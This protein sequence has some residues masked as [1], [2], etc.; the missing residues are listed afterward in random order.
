MHFMNSWLYGSWYVAIS[1]LLHYELN[2][3][4]DWQDLEILVFKNIEKIEK[5]VKKNTRTL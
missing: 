1:K 4:V 3:R 2:L 5:I